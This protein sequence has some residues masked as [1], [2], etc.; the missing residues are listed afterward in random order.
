MPKIKAAPN[1]EVLEGID[2]SDLQKQ[3]LECARLECL[4]QHL[5]EIADQKRQNVENSWSGL[6][7]AMPRLA[8]NIL[9]QALQEDDEIPF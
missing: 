4:I 8:E 1:D 2:I 3:T 5:Q 6:F 9:K 7:Q